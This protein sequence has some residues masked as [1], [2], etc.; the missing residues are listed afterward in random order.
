MKSLSI[1]FE[2]KVQ[3]GAVNCEK[4]ERLCMRQNIQGYPTLRLQLQDGSVDTYQGPLEADMVEAWIK[5][6]IDS[7]LIQFASNQQ[8]RDVARSDSKPMLVAYSVPQCGPC[9]AIKPAL[10]SAARELDEVVDVGVVNC[11][12]VPNACH[13]IPYFPYIAVVPRGSSNIERDRSVITV[14]RRFN[15]PADQALFIAG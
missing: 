5:D 9:Q 14:N 1:L 6:A 15:G 8:L 7:K 4:N 11:D 2:D 12:A 10:R 3:F 13:G